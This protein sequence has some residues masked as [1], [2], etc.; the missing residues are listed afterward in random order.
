M[1]EQRLSKEEQIL[2]AVKMTLT[3][4]IKDTATAPGMK[5]PLSETTIEDLRQ[6]LSLI[7]AREQ[8]LAKDSGRPMNMRPRYIDEPRKQS[9]VVVP[10]Q[11][12]RLAKNKKNTDS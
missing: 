12:T 9:A 8:E 5:H 2:R 7:S 4:V 3:G 6:C 1:N 10:L 11:T